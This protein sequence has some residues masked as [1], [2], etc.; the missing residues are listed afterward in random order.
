MLVIGSSQV[1]SLLSNLKMVI[2]SVYKVTIKGQIITE[3]ITRHLPAFCYMIILM[4]LTQLLENKRFTYFLK[5]HTCTLFFHILRNFDKKNMIQNQ[6]NECAPS[7]DSDQPE[8][9]SSLI[10]VFTVRMKKARVLSYPLSAQ[11]R[12]IRLG[13][14]PG[15]SS[16]D[17]QSFVGF[18][19]SWL[20]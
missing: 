18:V 12:L 20:I 3:M 8:H 1:T 7:E 19:V 5:I 17:A 15:C 9:P 10:R 6:Q 4:S 2:L 16:L 13:G 14:C 11:Q